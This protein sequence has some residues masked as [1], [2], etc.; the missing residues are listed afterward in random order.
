MI[1]LPRSIKRKFYDKILLREDNEC[2]PWVGAVNSRGYG[3]FKTLDN[4]IESAH[5][6]AWRIEKGPIPDGLHVLHKCDNK[7]CMN[8]NHMWL[9]THEENIRDAAK[10]GIMGNTKLKREQVIEIRDS[11][12]KVT[13]LAKIYKVSSATISQIKHGIGRRHIQ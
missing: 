12:E 6:V 7:L 8:T 10:K 2:K 3:S 11:K 5:R 1:D 4:K 13:V 9:G